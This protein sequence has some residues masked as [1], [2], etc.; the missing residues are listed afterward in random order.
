MMSASGSAYAWRIKVLVRSSKVMVLIPGTGRNCFSC[1][2]QTQPSVYLVPGIYSGHFYHVQIKPTRY[3]WTGPWGSWI[4]TQSAHEG[5]VSPKHRMPLPLVFI[6]CTG[7]V[8]TIY[9]WDQNCVDLYSTF[10]Y[11]PSVVLPQNKETLAF[12]RP[13]TKR[14][15]P[16]VA[17]AL[18]HGSNVV[19]IASYPLNPNGYYI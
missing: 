14:T 8:A 19:G 11:T 12:W 17:V 16:A 13:V 4:S 15:A 3:P 18:I 5:E 7:C 10:H 1:D 9:Q 6:C 2:L